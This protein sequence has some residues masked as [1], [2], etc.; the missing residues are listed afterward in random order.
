MPLQNK[1]SFSAATSKGKTTKYA[2]KKNISDSDNDDDVVVPKKA[3]VSGKAEVDD[4]GNTYWEVC[5]ISIKFRVLN[6]F[7][8]PFEALT[9]YACQLVLRIT[10]ARW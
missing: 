7:V 3:K 4:E 6:W 8:C 5:L 2:N 1:R 10:I 9:N